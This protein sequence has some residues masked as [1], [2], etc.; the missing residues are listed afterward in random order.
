[1][2]QLPREVQEANFIEFR[3]KLRSGEVLSASLERT[4]TALGFSGKLSVV[5]QNGR[6]MRSAYEESYAGI[7]K[8]T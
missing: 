5:L 6:V 2:V 8:I 3:R 1:M 4:L 7:R